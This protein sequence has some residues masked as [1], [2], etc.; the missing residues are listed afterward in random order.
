MSYVIGVECTTCTSCCDP[1]VAGPLE[2]KDGSTDA[3][4]TVKNYVPVEVCDMKDAV[5]ACTLLFRVTGNTKAPNSPPT[6]QGTAGPVDVT[7]TIGENGRNT[8]LVPIPLS[9]NLC[10]PILVSVVPEDE[11]PEKEEEEE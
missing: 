10:G 1:K 4:G 5:I 2:D 6:F 9:S 7:F 3:E 11:C 8:Q